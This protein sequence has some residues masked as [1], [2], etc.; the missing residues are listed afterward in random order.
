MNRP[1]SLLSATILTSSA[2]AIGVT[3]SV[4]NVVCSTPTVFTFDPASITWGACSH[5]RSLIGQ[6]VVKFIFPNVLLPD[7]KVNE[8]AS[9]GFASFRIR[10]RLPLLPG[11]VIENTANIYFDFNDP[12]ITEPSVLVAEFSTGLTEAYPSELSL[13]PV[14]VSDLLT[15]RASSGIASLR[16]MA[17]DGREVL[18]SNTRGSGSSIDVSRLRAGAYLLIAELNNGTTARAR[19]IKN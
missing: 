6:G 12:V 10:P 5:A 2:F 14:P 7:C 16:I 8:P 9:H 3:M 17:A 4:Q 19:F 18:P 1:Y 11:T 13:T 15:V